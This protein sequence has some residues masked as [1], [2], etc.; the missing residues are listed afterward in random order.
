[1][2]FSVVLSAEQRRH[3]WEDPYDVDEVHAEEAR[4]A[5]QGG[6]VAM[7]HSQA[8]TTTALTNWTT[9]STGCF[10]LVANQ[11]YQILYRVCHYL[12]RYICVFF[13]LQVGGWSVVY[14][15]LTFVTVRGAGHMV[16]TSRP[17]QA[18]QLFEHFL[19]NHNL[20]SKP[21]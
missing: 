8:G 12:T 2:S 15:G 10:Q 21:F 6:L 7:V 4:P 3:G 5:H 18:L 13:W 20:P 16:P 14:D 11:S 19:A 17:E 9:P 1:M